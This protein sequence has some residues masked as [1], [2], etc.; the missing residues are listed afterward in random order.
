MDGDADGVADGCDI[1]LEG[2]DAVDRD[3]DGVPDACDVCESSDDSVDRDGDGVPDD[4]DLC[5]GEDDSLDADADTVPDGCDICP[6]GDDLVD[7]DGDEVPDDCDV[8]PLDALDDSDGDGVCD[9]DDTC[10]GEDDTLDA[11]EDTIADGCDV[12]DGFDDLVNTDGDSAPD[13]CDICP[14][15]ALDDSDGDTVC[16]SDDICP[17][18][19][20]ADDA[21]GDTVPDG[22]DLCDGENDTVDLNADS[23]PDCSQSL[24]RNGQFNT[25]L[26]WRSVIGTAAV[27]ASSLDSNGVPP[28]GSLSIGAVATSSTVPPGTFVGLARGQSPS[29]SECISVTPGAS[30]GSYFEVLED[31]AGGGFDFFAVVLNQYASVNCTGGQTPVNFGPSGS[32]YDAGPTINSV[33]V[34]IVRMSDLFGLAVILD[35]FS[36]IPL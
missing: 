11:D 34:S 3:D 26:G 20:D 9:S 31:T 17:G 13:G 12:C 27:T 18:A 7:T 16:D 32:V 35:N 29:G 15:D 14:L 1:C 22:C 30:Y 21:D 19:D 33:T 10:A 25:L 2:D 23:I 5:P 6:D 24:I 28:S 8:C 4:C 36:F